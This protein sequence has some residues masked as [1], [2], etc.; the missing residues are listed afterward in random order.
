VDIST[1]TGKGPV[2]VTPHH[3]ATEAALEVMQSGGNAA[4]AVIAAD[5][6]L[7][8]VLPTTCGIGGDLFALVHRPGWARPEVLNASGRGGS[9]LDAA[10]LRAAGHRVMP[11]R[12]PETVTVPGCVDGWVALA[13]K[14]GTSP[15]GA[16]HLAAAIALGRDG[17]PVSKEFASDL[18]VVAKMV[19]GQS[20]AAALYPGGEP[21]AQGTVLRRPDLAATLEGIRDDG[22]TA[23][24]EGSVAA[25]IAAATGAVLTT[26]DLAANQPDWVEPAGARVLGLEAWTV[27]PNSQGY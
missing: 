5:A 20:S 12:A 16:K 22:R 25:Q 14:H 27:P 7:G 21:P 15:L 19:Q 9:G 8:M 26:D 23:F 11:Y 17:F 1:Y 13:A 2:A 3:L 24:Y 18:K 6:V 4:D 10:K